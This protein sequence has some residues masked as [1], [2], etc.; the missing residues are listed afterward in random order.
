[1]TADAI[2]FGTVN[3][4][5]L[6][7]Y[8]VKRFNMPGR[9]A[10]YAKERPTLGF[11]P[12]DTEELKKSDG[13]YETIKVG[14]GYSASPDWV[15]GNKNHNPSNTVRWNVTTPFAQ[16]GFVAFDNLL[17]NRNNLATLMDV[18]GS[19]A[20]DVRDGMLD[21]TEFE[22]WND[23][24]G[25]RGRA[26]VVSGTATLLVTLATASDVYNFPLNA[27]VTGNTSADGSGTART[28]R[29]RVS[30]LDPQAGKVTL[31]RTVDN[32]SVITTNDY[33]HVVA[34]A[35]KYMP[36]IPTFIPSTAPS[37]TLY[38]VTRS[39]NPAT[40]G[41]RFS[42]QGSIA[43]TISTSFSFM[44]R[45]V[46][47]SKQRYVVILSTADWLRL[48]YEREGKVTKDDAAIQKWGLS[49]LAVNSTYGLITA[50]SVPQLADGRGYII[51][52]ST[53][54]LYTLKNLPH[55]IDEDGQTFIRGREGT[56]DGYA[57]GDFVKMQM[58]MWKTLLC[59]MPMANATFPT[60]A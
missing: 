32:S 56:P 39:A 37:D 51:D 45:W 9:D 18:K 43:E 1:M 49:G 11:L 24:T 35:G 7:D 60:T 17:L 38:G 14:Q 28:N 29:Y 22:L 34:S 53:W 25:S 13:F 59:F 58:R 16:Y 21:N 40:S 19:E 6:A 26:A 3:T 4:L 8:M 55:V 36:G 42:F 5:A 44:G 20:D 48:S 54:K 47:K 2:N 15:E 57:N 31:T 10:A 50:I 30:D 52:W 27:I 46:K 41:W 12:R 23:G 33:I